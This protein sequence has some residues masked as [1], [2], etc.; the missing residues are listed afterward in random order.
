MKHTGIFFFFLV[1]DHTQAVVG[2]LHVSLDLNKRNFGRQ[3]RRL[4]DCIDI[5]K[6]KDQGWHETKELKFTDWTVHLIGAPSVSMCRDL[7]LTSSR[8]PLHADH[9]DLEGN[10]ECQLYKTHLVPS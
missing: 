7:T 6:D 1:N 8:Q 2:H 3:Q 4:W 9:I 5:H 10:F